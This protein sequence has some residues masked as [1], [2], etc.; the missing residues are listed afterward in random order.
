M[1][2]IA[3]IEGTGAARSG[4]LGALATDRVVPKRITGT[5]A[6]PHKWS[7]R[8]LVAYFSSAAAGT[9]KYV[10]DWPVKP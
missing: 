1:N 9:R 2:P 3:F 5:P 7:P 4:V 10:R 8:A 6:S